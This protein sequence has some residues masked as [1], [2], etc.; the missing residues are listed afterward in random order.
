MLIT[1][2]ETRHYIGVGLKRVG[3]SCEVLDDIAE[4]FI[5]QGLAE[6]SKAKSKLAQSENASKLK[7]KKK[8][9]GGY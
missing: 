2:K 3:E 6:E 4:Q 1:F 7:R 9:T 5:E 8:E